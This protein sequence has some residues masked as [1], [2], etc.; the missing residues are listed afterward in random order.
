M[1]C[2]WCFCYQVCAANFGDICSVVG[3]QATEE[4]LVSVTETKEE[5]VHYK[6]AHEVWNAYFYPHILLTQL[7][8]CK[9]DR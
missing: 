3:Q 6:V 4:M 2:Q 8:E 1:K 5:A 9:P 7:P